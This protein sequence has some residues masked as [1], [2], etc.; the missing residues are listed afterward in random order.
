MFFDPAR[1][2]GRQAL[3]ELQS[4]RLRDAVRLAA[5]SPFYSRVLRGLDLESLRGLEDLA[6]IP[7]TGKEHLREIC[8]DGM[9]N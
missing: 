5:R 4:I 6:S 8:P 2:P 9:L 3:E 1:G 7:L